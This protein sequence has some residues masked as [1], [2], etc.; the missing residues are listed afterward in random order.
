LTLAIFLA[1]AAVSVISAILVI[2]QKNSVISALYLVVTLASQAVLYF[3]LGATFIGVLQIIVYAG[4][5][6]VLFLFVI[7]LLNLKRDEFG[8]D[9]KK[10]QRV[11][12]FLLTLFLAIEILAALKIGLSGGQ[13]LTGV[14]AKVTIGSPAEV[15]R[16]LFIDYL[17]P[18]EI[19]SIL[20]LVAILG[21]IVLVKKRF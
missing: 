11:L 2:S 19:V 7:M 9:R 15:A 8:P 20:L 5:I 16:S 12:A 3:L 17:Y 13:A 14:T 4:A 10:G 18:F 6:M 21:V 1:L